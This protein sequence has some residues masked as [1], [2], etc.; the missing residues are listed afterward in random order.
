MLLRRTSRAGGKVK[1]ETLANLK[2]LPAEAIDAIDT[3]LKG[4]RLV[5][6]EQAFTITRSIPHG[7]VAAVAAM[8]GKLASLGVPNSGVCLEFCLTIH[9]DGRNLWV[10]PHLAPTPDAQGI[11]VA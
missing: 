11:H 4:Q 2:P 5:P 3:V 10:G 8:A 6:A 9:R 7:H 1:H